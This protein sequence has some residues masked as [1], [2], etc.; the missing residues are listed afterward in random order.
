MP[1]D[2]AADAGGAGGVGGVGG[3]DGADK[4][5]A[6]RSS[7]PE[8]STTPGAGDDLADAIEMGAATSG[9]RHGETRRRAACRG[10]LR[11]IAMPRS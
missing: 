8:T 4:T 9:S 6:A 5:V 1:A 3:A 2:A 11:E 10:S 7:L